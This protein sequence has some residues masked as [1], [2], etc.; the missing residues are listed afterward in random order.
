ML[1]FQHGRVADL[2]FFY[3]NTRELYK[4]LHVNGYTRRFDAFNVFNA[5]GWQ[6]VVSIINA[7][8]SNL[9]TLLHRAAFTRH[10]PFTRQGNRTRFI[11][12]TLDGEESGP[13]LPDI[14]LS[15]H[16]PSKSNHSQAKLAYVLWRRVLSYTFGNFLG[17]C[18]E[19]YSSICLNLLD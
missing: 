15:Y 17:C 13:A 4:W 2:L 3:S 10:F 14:A 9:P 1:G 11:S 19:P 18:I 12:S 8:E 5:F 7:R 6:H 16:S